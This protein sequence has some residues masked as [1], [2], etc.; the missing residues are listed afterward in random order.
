MIPKASGYQPD[1]TNM[2]LKPLNYLENSQLELI[3]EITNRSVTYVKRY[4]PH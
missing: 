2:L 1:I 4:Y 3:F